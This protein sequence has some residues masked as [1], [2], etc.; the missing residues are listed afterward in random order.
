MM[1]AFVSGWF[2]WRGVSARRCAYSSA[3]DSDK[4][5][6]A[7]MET[8]STRMSTVPVSK[9]NGRGMSEIAI[10]ES[11]PTVETKLS[12]TPKTKF[13]NCEARC[14]RD[15]FTIWGSVALSVDDVYL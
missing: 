8:A 1:N 13:R 4:K 11:R 9:I 12:S 2:P 6:P 10:P 14:R 15:V 7:A 3:D 5:L